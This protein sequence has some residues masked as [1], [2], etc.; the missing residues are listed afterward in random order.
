MGCTIMKALR[1]LVLC[2]AACS[3]FMAPVLQRSIALTVGT[4]N[5]VDCSGVQSS[6]QQGHSWV[7]SVKHRNV[8][9]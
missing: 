5:A 7:A 4:P 2:V 8:G 3:A 9:E 1:F 6:R